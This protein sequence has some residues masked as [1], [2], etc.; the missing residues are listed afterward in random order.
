MNRCVG[1]RHKSLFYS[2]QVLLYSLMPGQLRYI[3]EGV[4]MRTYWLRLLSF[5]FILGTIPVALIGMISYHIAGSDIENKVRE[6]NMH[7]LLQTQMRMEQMFRTLEKSVLQFTNTPMV[8]AAIGEAWTVRDFVKVNEV[9]TGL[10]N[11]QTSVLINQAYLANMDKG[12]VVGLDVFKPI[13]EF[14]YA[15]MFRSYAQDPKS[16]FL[17]TD[18]SAERSKLEEDPK[19]LTLVQKI[20]LISNLTAPK[21]LVV[22]EI[23]QEDILK[24]LGQSSDFGYFYMIDQNGTHFL[25]TQQ[26]REDYGEISRQIV[27]RL[28]QE[29]QE[30]AFHGKINGDQVIVTYRSSHYNGWVYVSTTSM[31]EVTKQ[32]KNI[33]FVTFG[34]C[35]A[36]IVFV[37]VSAFYGSFR[38]YR[39]IR[40]L[41]EV[42][43]QT[44]VESPGSGGKNELNYIETSVRTL[45]KSR[46]QLQ[47]QLSGQLRYL[48]EY[49]V[50]KL[51]IG[52]TNGE[53]LQREARVY[54]FPEGWKQV[55]VMTVQIDSLQNTRFHEHDKGLLLFAINNMVG[56]L[57]EPGTRFDPILFDQS[58]VTLVTIGGESSQLEV[59]EQLYRTAEKVQHE[60]MHYLQ[61]QVSIGI[62]RPFSSLSETV[63]AYG[64]S[65]AALKSRISLG[66]GIIVHYDDFT[67]REESGTAVYSHLNV[68]EDRIVRCLESNEPDQLEEAFQAY[69][70]ALFE[71]DSFLSEH[72]AILLQ[73]IVKILHLV[74]EQGVT[75]GKLF[76]GDRNMN[77]LCA[78]N[79]REEIV[80][81][82]RERL[83]EPVAGMLA[84][85]EETQYIN[86]A[87]RMAEMIHD[88]FLSDI[89]LE[90]CAKVL[91]YHPVYLS[92]VF[93]K[94]MGVAFSDYLHDYRMNWAKQMLETTD[95]KISEI[96]EKLQYKNT[97]AFIR[98]FRKSVGMTPGQYRDYRKALMDNR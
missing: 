64:E 29:E 84:H 34:V 98:T 87:N 8:K 12:W 92:R 30:G 82:F 2:F 21:G 37:L 45:W 56:E 52:Q 61:L 44:G 23:L 51:F 48:K 90:L 66:H 7:I 10:V 13:E 96:S 28:E 32:T 42:V 39:P 68:M 58:Q 55:A 35:L 62:S 31:A 81:W 78:L 65:L 63:R 86:I 93:K 94:H 67:S 50:L 14:K 83:F 54:G 19:T 80:V 11:L 43:K 22:V 70:D 36:I 1:E 41:L 46:S 17:V 18:H 20:P 27:H 16:L 49:L 73:L 24:L 97:S 75:V 77:E 88:G 72:I 71:K 89:S 40:S 74:R 69:L 26:Q 95:M 6:S 79:T 25:G 60:V 15:A 38:M 85:Q 53:P 47:Q 91:N 3:K 9:T 5:S 33:A 57:L 59:K 76:D 4:I